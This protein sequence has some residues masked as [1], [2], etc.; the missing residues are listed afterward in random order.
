MKALTDIANRPDSAGLMANIA[1]AVGAAAI[2]NILIF[3]L[4]WNSGAQPDLR[5]AISPP[6][7]VIGIIWIVLFGLMGAA[8]WFV[9]RQQSGVPGSNS[10]LILVL[11]AFC[12]AYPFY[13]Q[14]LDNRAIGL[15][16][17]FLTFALAAWIFFRV[18]PENR[19]AASL[20]LPVLIWVGYA[21][22]IIIRSIQLNGLS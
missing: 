12:L 7:Y 2:T 6:G 8:R 20:I 19:E 4:G 17:N 3:A 18:R 10:K 21:T 16:G 15:I 11:I 5:P 13:T 1:F 22:A 9:V 14:G